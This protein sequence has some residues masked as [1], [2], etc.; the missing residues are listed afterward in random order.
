MAITSPEPP[1]TSRLQDAARLVLGLGLAF[2][3]TS[4]LAWARTDFRAQ[5]PGWVPLDVDLVVI[6]SGIVEIALGLALVLLAGRRVLLGLVAAAFFVAVFPGNVSQYVDGEAAFGL[7]SDLARLLRLPFQPVL[8]AW[9]LWSTG[10]WAWWQARRRS[11]NGE[12][13]DHG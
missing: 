2:A 11:A 10:A 7:D 3:G 12:G 5:V 1:P 13:D 8:V 6:L 4:H 9:A